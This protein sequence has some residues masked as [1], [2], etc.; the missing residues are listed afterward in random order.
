MEK[1]IIQWKQKY[2]SFDED[3]SNFREISNMNKELKKTVNILNSNSSYIETEI[4]SML[5]IL[6]KEDFI[7]NENGNWSLTIKGMIASNLQEIHPLAF[8]ELL[9]GEVLRELSTIDIIS[10]ISCLTSVSVPKKDCI[11]NIEYV[12]CNNNIK[13]ALNKMKNK[14]NKFY[15]IELDNRMN[16]I[17][18]YDLHWNMCELIGKWC[19]AKTEQECK[20]V[21]NEAEYYGICL[22][23]FVK[24]ILKINA[25]GLELEK[26]C[27]IKED[28]VLYEKCK[29][30]PNMTL[31]SIATN[32]SLYL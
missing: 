2:R 25:I 13:D 8:S 9:L 28:L 29:N 10:V 19:N 7:K 23:E 14:F 21:Y 15:D 11:L 1:K 6:E 16:N 27:L 30:I 12:N 24:A 17:D 26:V 22:G 3:N 18:N 20:S 5:D 4:S 31:K 32:Q